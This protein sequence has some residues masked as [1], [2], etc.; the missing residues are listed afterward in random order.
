MARRLDAMVRSS[1]DE[2]ADMPL[3]VSD[4]HWLERLDERDEHEAT[5]AKRPRRAAK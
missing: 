2:I 3:R 1:L 5:S 4:E